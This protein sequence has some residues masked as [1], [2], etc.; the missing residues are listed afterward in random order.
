M[1]RS[2]TFDGVTLDKPTIQAIDYSIAEGEV[3]LIDGKRDQDSESNYGTGYT[4]LCHGTDRTNLELLKAKIGTAGTLMLDTTNAG[5]Y[6]IVSFREGP[7]PD[8]LTYFFYTI[9]LRRQT[10]A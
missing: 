8:Y 2:I 3:V 4:I 5:T 1:A 10:A 6:R 9:T 7:A